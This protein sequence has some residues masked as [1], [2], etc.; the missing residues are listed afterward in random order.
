MFRDQGEQSIQSQ[1]SER[2]TV[3]A[4]VRQKVNENGRIHQVRH[5]LTMQHHEYPLDVV[6]RQAEPEKSRPSI[7][8]DPFVHHEVEKL[9]LANPLGLYHTACLRFFLRRVV[10][11]VEYAGTTVCLYLL[12]P[13]PLLT[14]FRFSLDQLTGL[15]FGF[16]C[17]ESIDVTVFCGH[18][19]ER[20]EVV[21]QVTAED[22]GTCITGY[23]LAAGG[24]HSIS[25]LILRRSRIRR[26]LPSARS[27]TEYHH[28]S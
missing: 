13:F 10:R 4:T 16:S 22:V 8:E 6:L 27:R 14:G 25:W 28:C 23:Q 11:V 3:V 2:S 24:K 5:D 19:C 17:P 15:V 26:T 12:F 7:V 1:E 18:C 9:M 21:Q 20:L